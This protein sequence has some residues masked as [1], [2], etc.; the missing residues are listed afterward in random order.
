MRR[1]GYVAPRT[2]TE[3]IL[4]KEFADILG[5]ERIG[6]DDD[7]FEL[8][9][10]SLS[11][12]KLVERLRRT[13]FSTLPL[14]ALF[15]SP[16]ISSLANWIASADDQARS[17]L[18]R[19]RR[20]TTIP[21]LYCI[22]PG[23][24]S[25]IRYQPLVD[26]LT[27]ERP[28]YGVQSRSLLDPTFVDRSIDEMAAHY[29]ASI[30]R[31]QSDGPYFLTGWCFGGAIA[32]AMAA[33][34]EEQGE[35][36]AFLGL[37]DSSTVVVPFHRDASALD[38]F[39]QLAAMEGLQLGD[40]PNE[41]DKTYLVQASAPLSDR[42]RL[43]L[44]AEWGREQ[45]YWSNMSTELFER[46]FADGENSARMLSELQL[47]RIRA[48][49]HVWWAK[50]TLDAIGGPPVDWSAFTLG[51]ATTRVLAGTHEDILATADLH[52][53]VDRALWIAGETSQKQRA[54]I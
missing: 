34:L 15:A 39:Q 47:T 50:A 54:E 45:G 28:V 44:A 51:G 12:M 11:G 10:S 41:A 23:G 29:V 40:R 7:F 33:L 3:W 5:V 14:T 9:G 53:E 35:E 36:V 25:V 4:A 18:V 8:G 43:L 31:Q 19:M 22:H 17:S 32:M 42:E 46:L 37:I 21:P 16:T 26:A 13:M 6:V 24:G 52:A 1:D 38:Y 20:G 30:R 27:V 48:P 49:I 2:V